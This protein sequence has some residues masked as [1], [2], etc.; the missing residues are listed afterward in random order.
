KECTPCPPFKSPGGLRIFFDQVVKVPQGLA[1]VVVGALRIGVHKP[2]IEQCHFTTRAALTAH[3][4]LTIFRQE[5]G[6]VTALHHLLRWED[7]AR[8]LPGWQGGTTSQHEYANQHSAQ[9]GT[10]H[11]PMPHAPLRY[12]VWPGRPV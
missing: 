9:R 8:L 12:A 6:I 2:Q 7:V 4:Y 5:S 3:Q 11:C 10:L 1:R